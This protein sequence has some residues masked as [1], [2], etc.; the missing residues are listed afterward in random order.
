LGEILA[1]IHEAIRLCSKANRE[2]VLILI[3]PATLA[4]LI[5]QEYGLDKLWETSMR[6]KQTVF[7]YDIIETLKVKDFF[8]VDNRSW[9]EQKW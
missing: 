5:E 8:V 1:Q 6:S 3:H 7:G 9:A 2:P 4:M